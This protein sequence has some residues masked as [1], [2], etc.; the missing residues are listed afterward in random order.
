MAKLLYFIIVVVFIEIVNVSKVIAHDEDLENLL[1]SLQ[2]C[3]ERIDRNEFPGSFNFLEHL[4]DRLEGYIRIIMAI[5]LVLNN[6]QVAITPLIANLLS[7][8]REKLQAL[9]TQI[10]VCSDQTTRHCRIPPQVASSGG[11]RRYI[12]T[13]EQ[14]EVLCS[15]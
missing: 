9:R 5:S 14:M 6:L 1:L 2:D 10:S 15:T 13:A 4:R 7:L 3:V 12:I 11:R 8:L